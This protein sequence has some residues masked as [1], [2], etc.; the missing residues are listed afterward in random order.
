MGGL[1]KS[2][3]HMHLMCKRMFGAAAGLVTPLDEYT[4]QKL[5]DVC[6]APYL[7]PMRD[8][9]GEAFRDPDAPWLNASAVL[10]WRSGEPNNIDRSSDT[11][12]PCDSASDTLF[13]PC[14]RLDATTLVTD[15]ECVGTGRYSNCAACGRP[16]APQFD[17]NQWQL[18]DTVTFYSNRTDSQLFRAPQRP[19]ISR[20]ALQYDS[21]N[22]VVCKPTTLAGFSHWGCGEAE[23]YVG[24]TRRY[25]SQLEFAEWLVAPSQPLLNTSSESY[26]LPPFFSQSPWIELDVIDSDFAA[27]ASV[28]LSLSYLELHPHF[29]AR[30]IDNP[31]S[32][33]RA[34]IYM[35]KSEYDNVATPKP[36]PIPTATAV[37]D[38]SI[39]MTRSCD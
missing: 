30:G 22:G 10:A 11:E 31:D 27:D 6:A 5:I 28:D 17:V 9:C 16:L 12:Q 8:Q 13:Q 32:S 4:R 36:T 15:L 35:L 21:G 3:T 24:I 19:T 25:S 38:T 1:Y 20:F 33:A 34:Q 7:A 26:L 37:S 14:T 29:G 23:L 18:I 2:P 39:S